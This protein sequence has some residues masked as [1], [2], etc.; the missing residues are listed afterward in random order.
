MYNYDVLFIGSGH[1]CNHGAIALKMAGKK[2]ALVERDKNGGTCTNYGCDAKIVLDGPFEYQEGLA[3]Y[4]DLGIEEPKLN[5]K[6]MMAYKKSLIGAFDPLLGK[7]FTGAGLDLLHGQG[8]L[9]DEHTVEVDGKRY[10]AE[11]IVIGAGAR[12]S[13]LDIPGSEFIHDSK[14]FLDLDEIPEHVTFIGAGV[15][16]MEFASMVLALGKKATIVVHGDRALRQ[17]PANYVGNIIK[18]MESQGAVFQWKED[19]C[20]VEKTESGYRLTAASG[21]EIESDY[22]M[23]GTGRIANVE[24]LGLEKLG[25]EASSKGIVVD[26]HMR[27][28]VP[29]I[30]A[31]GDVVAKRIPKLTPTAEFE[32]NYIAAQILGQTDAPIQYPAIP[33][34]V[35]TLPRIAVAGVTV[36]EAKADPEEYKVVEVPFG[37]QNEWVNNREKESHMTFILDREGH[38]AGTALYTAEAAMMLDFLTLVINR[39]MTA[40]ELRNMIFAFPTQTYSLVSALIPEMLKR[41]MGM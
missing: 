8:T 12:D 23:E 24:G 4:K 40:M 25:I 27:T 30:F 10:T 36:D 26:D 34:L 7:L 16:T 37:L 21:L 17:Y 39:K 29:N 32:S 33:H 28:S 5:W 15:I 22:I 14:D 18:K 11:Y 38:L 3:R 6:N 31:S 13:K 1:S 20:K 2:V 35:F 9:I 41:Q 19:V